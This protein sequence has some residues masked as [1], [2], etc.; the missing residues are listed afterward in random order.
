VP[1][2]DHPAYRPLRD[3]LIAVFKSRSVAFGRLKNVIFLCG[4]FQSP[5]RDFLFQYLKKW[6]TDALVF[7]ADDVWARIAS[8]TSLNALAMEAQLAD[9]ADAVIIIVESPG[10]FAE[11]GAFSNSGPLRRKLLPILDK[12]YEQSQSFINT[13]PVSWVNADSVF[14]PALFVDLDSILLAADEITGRLARLN[15]MSR[16]RVKNLAEHP[17]HLLLMLRD[18]VGMIGPVSAHH[19]EQYVKAILDADP[20]HVLSLLGLAESLQLLESGRVGNET[21]YFVRIT[22]DYHP[23]V[24]KQFFDLPTERAKVL[25][26][27]QRIDSARAALSLLSR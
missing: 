21:Y 17:K 23:V 9:L 19:V 14:K 4:G 24:R 6:A 13:G 18:I 1:W 16:E 25:E 26:V 8:S 7:Q 12:R 27:L 10:T 20:P 3:E 15:P 22:D 2:F 5:R 11:L